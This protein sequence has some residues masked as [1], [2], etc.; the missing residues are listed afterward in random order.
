[1]PD[2]TR[3]NLC[4]GGA[5]L[6]RTLGSVFSMP[7]NRKRRRSGASDLLQSDALE[8][9]SAA[10]T[11][12]RASLESLPTMS[13]L[14]SA[15]V[16]PSISSREIFTLLKCSLVVDDAEEKAKLMDVASKATES[17]FNLLESRSTSLLTLQR[18]HAL[19]SFLQSFNDEV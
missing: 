15:A 9:L 19:A 5:M 1:M 14:P 16:S 17:S 7:A 13:H 11:A 2:A 8:Q 12:I 3:E 18:S 4:V 6:G 10:S